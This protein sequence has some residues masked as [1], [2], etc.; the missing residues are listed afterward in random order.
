METREGKEPL[1][2]AAI[3]FITGLEGALAEEKCAL[4][5]AEE[6]SLS[7]KERLQQTAEELTAAENELSSLKEE[8]QQLIQAFSAARQHEASIHNLYN[9][10]F[11]QLAE[12]A[13]K[14]RQRCEEALHH[15]QLALEEK[16]RQNEDAAA[17]VEHA[18]SSFQE[19]QQLATALLSEQ[20]EQLQ[21]LRDEQQQAISWLEE[22]VTAAASRVAAAQVEHDAADK[23]N[24]L[25]I[26]SLGELE[27]ALHE[28]EDVLQSQ[29]EEL[30]LLPQ[31]Q[32]N[33]EAAL[34]QQMEQELSILKAAEEEAT[35]VLNEK[36]AACEKAQ[37]LADL[38]KSSYLQMEEKAASILQELRQV[39]T[40][41]EKEAAAIAAQ[42]EKVL[43]HAIAGRETYA[44]LLAQAK[45]VDVQANEAIQA[46]INLRE[47]VLHLRLE[48][49][50]LRNAA[51]VAANLAADATISRLN[52]D[53]E[54]ADTMAEME[55]AL[56]TAAE[57]AKRQSADKEAELAAAE[58]NSEQASAFAA[59]MR[60]QVRALE[61]K[62]RQVES[63]CL[64]TEQEMLDLSNRASAAS[65]ASTVSPFD[66]RI[67]ELRENY[68]TAAAETIALKKAADTAAQNLRLASGE[69]EKAERAFMDT[70]YQTRQLH[71]T[72][73]ANIAHSRERRRSRIAEIH[74]K[75]EMGTE[76]HTRLQESYLKKQERLAESENILHIKAETLLTEQKILTEARQTA[77]AATKEWQE[78]LTE[79]QAADT[80]ALQAIQ[81][82]AAQ[83]AVDYD[84]LMQDSL[85]ATN[86]T[87]QA[88]DMLQ[89]LEQE[90]KTL[91]QRLA[92]ERKS[93][94]KEAATAR[95]TAGEACRVAEHAVKNGDNALR[96]SELTVSRIK[97]QHSMLLAAL[98]LQKMRQDYHA[99][100][101]E[102]LESEEAALIANEHKRLAEEAAAAAR[103]E[104]H[105]LEAQ[106]RE[107]EAARRRKEE[108]K[109]RMEAEHEAAIIAAEAETARIAALQAAKETAAEQAAIRMAAG[110][111]LTREE[112]LAL[113][114][115]G[116][117]EQRMQRLQEIAIAE[118]KAHDFR[119]IKPAEADALRKEAAQLSDQVE[120]NGD[121]FES[122]RIT[123]LDIS[124]QRQELK[125]QRHAMG[126]R[127]AAQICALYRAEKEYDALQR[128]NLSIQN[129]QASAGATALPLILK[130]LKGMQK[131][132]TDCQKTIA[133]CR[134]ALAATEAEISQLHALQQET[135]K[136]YQDAGDLLYE[137]A[138]TWI[139]QKNRLMKL[140]AKLVEIDRELRDRN[141]IRQAAENRFAA[142]RQAAAAV[143]E[144]T[145]RIG[146][147][148]RAVSQA[149]RRKHR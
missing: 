106:Q 40:N 82:E 85:Q 93:T 51:L 125:A 81:Q 146:S 65:D 149:G 62:I 129:A 102:R 73:A 63:D 41:A 52:A 5:A 107:E 56:I 23:T 30:S 39:C 108:E 139:Y 43:H 79:K 90:Q 131:T 22:Q 70:V 104:Q 76:K 84:R 120:Q 71:S 95:I 69:V 35:S 11:R 8:Q 145:Q 147:V 122:A 6:E 92:E 88:L 25:F 34:R 133:T 141:E 134:T 130:T 110:E 13:E 83:A 143:S 126:P 3:G 55:R 105:R 137:L 2:N 86:E 14:Q 15:G 101:V 118:A 61:Q 66:S 32:E 64:A 7:I 48:D 114:E 135:E 31:Q 113:V 109:Q 112:N 24:S 117:L 72:Y 98:E 96:I 128:A 42:M 58:A 123:L 37:S 116:T 60:Q 80:A 121:L 19:K 136:K 59:Q 140:E 17:K 94:E 9:D 75:L 115:S 91:L 132:L 142:A 111:I 20:E 68:D 36:R 100:Q 148:K 78:K 18:A 87:Q 38:A 46:D 44:T 12:T 1:Q 45:E 29:Q 26:R 138:C 27:Q 28:V 16:R 10:R 47:Q 144:Q 21:L 99:A 97:K 54:M 49:H 33:E 74:A 89:E 119:W 57:E 127:W 50:D 53:S 103:A 67:S 77:A 124:R 4:V